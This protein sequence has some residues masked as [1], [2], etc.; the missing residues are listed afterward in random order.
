MTVRQL[1]A[2]GDITTSGQ[3]FTD[4]INEVA[5]TVTTRLKLFLGEYFRDI[6]DGTPWFEQVMNKAS[7]LSAKEAAIKNRIIRTDGV[8]Q[9]TSFE[10]NFDLPTRTYTVN[11]GILTPFGATQISVQDVI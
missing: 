1:Q 8:L 9:L 10:T 5:Q 4:E 3:Q 11:A 2:D 7:S 6:T